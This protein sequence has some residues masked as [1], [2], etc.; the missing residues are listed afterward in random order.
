VGEFLT[1]V[2]RTPP[3]NSIS[4]LDS[5]TWYSGVV[6]KLDSAMTLQSGTDPAITNVEDKPSQ[7]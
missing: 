2:L 3:S 4:I 7:P 6:P 1:G 5:R